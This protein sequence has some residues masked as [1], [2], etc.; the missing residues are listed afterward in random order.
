MVLVSDIAAMNKVTRFTSEEIIAILSLS[1]NATAIY[2]SE[3]IIIQA[4]ND[5]MIAFWDKDRSIVGYPLEEAVPE[6][7][8]QPFL[9]IIKNVWHTGISY[10]AHDTPALLKTGDQLQTFYFDF[11]YRAILN[12]EGKTTCILHSATDVT[13]RNINRLALQQAKEQADDLCREKNINEELSV[14]NQRLNISNAELQATQRNLYELTETLE[15]RV[16]SRTNKL[17]ESQI[18][19]EQAIETGKMG[20]W[21]INP[22]N[23]KVCMSDFIR[24]LFGFLPDHEILLSQVLQAIH[25]EY[26]ALL[27]S[28]LSRQISSDTE[29]PITNQITQQTKW[30][31]ATGRAF[32]D[33]S[34]QLI[35]YSGMV[36]DITEQVNGR[37]DLER[38]IAEKTAL[39]HDLRQNQQ[40]LQS[41]LD[42]MA[43]GVGIIDAKGNLVYVNTMAQQIFGLNA[44]ELQGRSFFD[45]QWRS[46]KVDGMPLADQEHPVAQMLEGSHAVHDQEIGIQSSPGERIFIS[47]NAAPMFGQQAELTGGIVTFMD[48]TNRRKLMQQKDEFISVASH[49][50]K[51]P[52]T[53]LKAALQL[54]DRMKGNPSPGIMNKLINQSNKSLTKLSNLVADLL[55]VNRITQGQLHLRKKPFML[56]EVIEDCC[57]HIRSAGTHTIIIKG[58][59]AFIVNAD[60]QQIDQILIN[61]INNAVKYAPESKE[62]IVS[63]EQTNSYARISVQ[64]KGP[65]VPEA[66]IPHLFDRYFRGDYSG[67]QFSGLGLGL[68]ICAEIIKKHGG[69]IGVDTTEGQGST[70]WFT[71]PL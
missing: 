9:N 11:V 36:I 37:M 51:T 65:G 56:S 4:A 29:Y 28:T 34:D 55:N 10:E 42:T 62:I 67:I 71:L 49:E 33:H 54:L 1:P 24:D 70:F 13:E 7:K 21:S 12:E 30:I 5:A 61:F 47:I 22:V 53:T 46:Q 60:E 50:L 20:T 26:R 38:I 3:Q 44:D 69:E 15:D 48:V 57:H 31:R 41:I 23:R 8:G 58:N 19:L 43:E 14:I 45:A 16:Q 18:K 27:T 64:D 68:Y 32:F 63:I 59:P 35:E 25:P 6:L 2:A 40:R 39:E 52:L 66:K 17:K